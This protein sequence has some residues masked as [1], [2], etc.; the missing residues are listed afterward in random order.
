MLRWRPPTMT[1][2]RPAQWSGPVPTGERPPAWWLPPLRHP[3]D[4]R[5]R[6]SRAIR[7]RPGRMSCSR[8]HRNKRWRWDRSGSWT[9]RRTNVQRSPVLGERGHPTRTGPLRYPACRCRWGAG[10]QRRSL[11]R[12]GSHPDRSGKWCPG[13]IEGCCRCRRRA[14]QFPTRTCSLLFDRSRVR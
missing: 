4:P 10:P 14:G 12:G 13:R 2:S 1:S 5:D 11:A 7:H 6:G 8:D 9:W 3:T